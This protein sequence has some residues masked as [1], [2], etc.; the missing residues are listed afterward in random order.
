MTRTTFQGP[1][2]PIRSFYGRVRARRRP[3]GP[4]LDAALGAPRRHGSSHGPARGLYGPCAACDTGPRDCASRQSLCT[5]LSTAPRVGASRQS[6]CTGFKTG[7]RDGAFKQPLCT[8][9]QTGPCD[10]VPIRALCSGPRGRPLR[11]AFCSGPITGSRDGASRHF[12]CTGRRALETAPLEGPL[13]RARDGPRE[14][15]LDGPSGWPDGRGLEG[16]CTFPYAV[17]VRRGAHGPLGGPPLPGP[18]RRACE[19]GESPEDVRHDTALSKS[20]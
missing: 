16:R 8:G 15:T 9:L 10:G 12:F 6:L 20:I 13:R 17:S 7:P 14:G 1:E 4:G 11:R 2:A 19:T 18:S 3:D 5:G